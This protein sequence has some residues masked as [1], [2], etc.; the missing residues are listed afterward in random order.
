M[1]SLKD[2]ES[3]IAYYEYQITKTKP[4]I[5]RAN[6]QIRMLVAVI[7][8]MLETQAKLGIEQLPSELEEIKQFDL[9][10]SLDIMAN[11]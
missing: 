6:K 10:D 9:D 1:L 5:E 7:L 4:L 8:Q 2:I 11:L 3:S